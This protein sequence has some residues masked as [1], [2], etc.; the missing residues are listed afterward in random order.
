MKY[1]LIAITIFMLI[2]LYSC[3]TKEEEKKIAEIESEIDDIRY[4]Q[5]NVDS[6]ERHQKIEKLENERHYYYNI[7]S[8][9]ETAMWITFASIGL[10]ILL[11]IILV[12]QSIPIYNKITKQDETIDEQAAQLQSA[13][14]KRLELIPNLVN[15]VRGYASHENETL[16]GV[17]DARSKMGSVNID[18]SKLSPT[19]IATFLAKQQEI[20]YGLSRLLGI[21]EN[22]PNLKA[23]LRFQDL[24]N[25]LRHTENNI[26]QYRQSFNSSVARYNQTIRNFPDSIIASIMK[27]KRRDYL[28]YKSHYED[29]PTVSF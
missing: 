5:V 10:V 27:F 26:N 28:E 6:Y 23:D 7:I 22:Y 4:Q 29:V 18:I 24:H 9:K 1:T 25:D 13:Y 17:M 16:R 19:Q 2:F 14:R 20:T 11:L 12:V 8:R 15:V 3:S 21:V